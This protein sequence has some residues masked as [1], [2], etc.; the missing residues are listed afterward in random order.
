[1]KKYVDCCGNMC[2]LHLFDFCRLLRLR[3][4]VIEKIDN[5]YVIVH[6]VRYL[7]KDA[8]GNDFISRACA[9]L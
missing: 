7:P 4:Q 9:K 6:V 3:F 8:T 5:S 1:M 2:G